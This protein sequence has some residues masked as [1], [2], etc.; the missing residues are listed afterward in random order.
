MLRIPSVSLFVLAALTACGGSSS[1]SVTG[2][3]GPQQVTIVDSGQ[4]VG[5]LRLPSNL[6]AVAG[7]DY[8]TDPTRMWVRDDSMDTL[9]TVNMILDMLSQTNYADQTNQGVYRCLVEEDERNEGGGERGQTGP[10]YEE[11]VVESTRA[12]NAAPQI[13]KFWVDQDEAMGSE[14]EAIIYGLMTIEAEPSA[15]QPLG[16]FTLQFKSLP[17]SEAPTSTNYFFQG[18]LRTIDRN[19]G[20]TEV[21][22]YM[23]EGDP[24]GAVPAGE[25]HI[26]ERVHV[27][28]NPD[29]DSGHAYSEYKRVAN[30]MP[31]IG[32]WTEQAEYQMQFNSDYVALMDVTNGNTI[33]VK[34]RNDFDTYV[35]RYG[36]YDNVTEARIDQLSGFPIEDAS[37]NYGWAGFHGIWFPEDVSVTNGMTVYRRSYSTDTL[38]PYTVVVVPGRLEKRT[39]SSITLGD[40]VDED[41]Q[42]FDPSAGTEIMVRYTGTDFL[43]VANRSGNSW[44]S[45]APVSIAGSFTTGEWLHFWSHARGS[46]EF[47]WPAT[48]NNS[49]PAYVWSSQTIN[50]DSAEL[51]AGNLTLNGY[52]QMLKSD[53]TS[54]QANFVGA[55]TPYLPDATGVAAGNQT[56]VFDKTTLMLTLGGNDVNF[57]E[58][59][60]A[61][62]GPGMHG[63][64][65]G[66][67]FEN[68]LAS[69]NDIPTETTTY[70]WNIGANEWNQLRT[71]KDS[72]GAYVAFTP[73]LRFNYTHSEVG[74]AFDGRS[75]Y[76]EWDGTNLHGMPYNEDPNDNRWYPAF[77]IPTS[78]TLTEN[79]NTYKVK[80]LE[81]EQIMVSVGDPNSVF[82]AQGFDLSS[83]L[84]AP[85]SDPWEDPAIGSRP[86][87]TDPPIY[88]GGVIQS[89]S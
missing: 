44:T 17:A 72:A 49:V 28:G 8:E 51:A 22:F 23:W 57:L 53:I 68:A 75:F 50:A 7:S 32:S 89:D 61:T 82:A 3:T 13:V 33:D 71:L 47:T 87:V 34:D 69:F 18:Y 15:D 41:M 60:T 19:D 62:S 85:T 65:C 88:V 11:W 20:L 10:V 24:D 70:N 84:S 67:L 77:N 39:R 42:M 79:S 74:S 25:M 26:R 27:V 38:T 66:P 31:G 80:Q 9:E 16:D 4:N 40:I 46:V 2:L 36:L 45:I 59:V 83:P 12:N 35:Y 76:L 48:L 52:F 14:V 37:G 56:Y 21:E 5:S 63:L 78:T 43:H 64:H 6:R 30:S 58:G 29:D 54:N 73:P 81:G 86:T 55:E 1:G